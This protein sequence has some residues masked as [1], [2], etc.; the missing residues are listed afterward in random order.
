MRFK[1]TET[2][3]DIIEGTTYRSKHYTKSTIRKGVYSTAV[4][5]LK[6]ANLDV[7]SDE[8]IESSAHIASVIKQ[9]LGLTGE[10]A[11]HHINYGTSNNLDHL[12]LI[13][14]ST[15]QD[16]HA[17]LIYQLLD[18]YGYT[19]N[20]KNILNSIQSIPDQDFKSDYIQLS[21]DYLEELVKCGKAFSLKNIANKVRHN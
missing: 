20:D 12:Y 2:I 9:L 6:N 1:L 13:E 18:T 8:V 14:K 4:A 5:K 17:K 15:H 16:M 11:I 10:W 3:N 21:K 7:S 19:L